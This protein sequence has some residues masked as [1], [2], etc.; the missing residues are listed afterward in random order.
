MKAALLMAALSLAPGARAATVEVTVAGVRNGLGEV[1]VAICTEDEFLQPT[2]T[3]IGQAPARDGDVVVRIEGVPPG[4]WAAQAF[5]DEDRDGKIGRNLLGIPTEGLGFSND[6]RFR[7]GP[8]SFADAAF[9][10]GSAGGRIRFS[11]RY[12]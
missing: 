11:L 2:C 9:Q 12:F 7:F 8:P 10:L 4:T 3:H 5:H 1:R 6:A